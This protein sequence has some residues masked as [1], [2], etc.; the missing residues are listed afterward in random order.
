MSEESGAERARQAVKLRLAELQMTN[1]QLAG[2]AQVDPKTVNDFLSG[3]RWPQR[4]SRARIAM[5]LQ[6]QLDAL[7]RLRQGEALEVA[8]LNA[9]GA[10]EIERSQAYWESRASMTYQR[11]QGGDTAA[12]AKLLALRDHIAGWPRV[13]DGAL[14]LDANPTIVRRVTMDLVDIM[15]S[16]GITLTASTPDGSAALTDLL[17][18]LSRVQRRADDAIERQD[19]PRPPRPAMDLAWVDD[20][21]LV[22][23]EAGDDEPPG[24]Y[25][26]D[27]LDEAARD[28]GVESTGQRRRREAGAAGEPPPD[29]PDDLEPR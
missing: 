8:Q 16:A 20:L 29:D 21:D 14:D 4:S 18:D 17:L 5:A 15:V 1:T 27:G 13:A 25:R 22:P 23:H 7:D 28:V 19:P 10:E 2:A 11:M 26:G 6:W 3:K 9:Q 12:I 24:F